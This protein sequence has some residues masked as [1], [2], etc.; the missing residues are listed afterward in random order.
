MKKILIVMTAITITPFVAVV[1]IAYAFK[2]WTKD[3]IRQRK[4]KYVK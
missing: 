1:G 2:E 4:E 3:E